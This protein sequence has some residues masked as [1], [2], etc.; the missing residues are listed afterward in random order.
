MQR[1]HASRDS[2]F[3]T[4][5]VRL[6]EVRGGRGVV[7][8]LSLHST[9]AE[10]SIN[11]AN[12]IKSQSQKIDPYVSLKCF[13]NSGVVYGFQTSIKATSVAWGWNL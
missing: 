8:V 2:R 7:T 11:Q 6:R 5:V 3:N 1:N 10:S 13:G 12:A 9:L 4:D